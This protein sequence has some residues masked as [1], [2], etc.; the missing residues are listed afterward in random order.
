MNLKLP[1]GLFTIRRAT[2]V[3]IKPILDLMATDSFRETAE[4]V[5]EENAYVYEKAFHLID[6][7][8][9]QLLAVVDD[10]QD[11]VVGTMQLT[12][13]PGLLREGGWRCNIESVRVNPGIRGNGLGAEMMRWAIDQAR[14]RGC[15]LVQLTSN[16]ERVRAHRFYER[17]GFTRSHYGFKLNL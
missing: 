15:R 11:N 3:D 17:L 16:S 2:V 13:I 4:K 9:H 7:D 10:S 12:F 6:G 8:P 1:G 14:A 5:T